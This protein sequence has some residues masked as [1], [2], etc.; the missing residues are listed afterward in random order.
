MA[1]A[2]STPPATTTDR[3]AATAP[4]LV[5]LDPTLLVRDECNAREHDTEPDAKLIT[6]VKELG[7]E[8]PISVRPLPDGTYGVF[9]GWR[10]A[11]AAQA[12]NASAEQDGRPVRTVNAYV[13]EDLVGNDAWTRFL[14]LVENDHRENMSERDTLKAQELSLIGMDDLQRRTA[15]KALGVG[16]NAARH[17]KAAQKLN[18]ASLRRS[19]A[20]GMDLEQTA[21]LAEVADAPRAEARLMGALQRD[22]EEGK[23]GRGHW[24][25]ELAL[26][27]ADLADAE[28]RAKAVADLKEAGA[29]LLGRVSS[30][31]KD[32]SKPLT[33]LTTALGNPLTEDNHKNCP[34]HSA[35]LDEEHRP[36]WHCADPAEYGHKVRPQPKKPKTEQ[37]ERKVEE[38][39]RTVAC[40]RAWK[41]AAGPRQEFIK[42]LVRGKTL[43]DE[44]RVF[45]QE[46]L[47]DLPGFYSSWVS[48]GRTETLALL[49]GAKE[50]EKDSPS[51]T[52]AH[53]P[54]A[55]LANLVFAQVAAA[56]EDTMREP[57]QWD[58]ARMRTVCVWEAPDRRQ[59]AYL[60]LLEALGKAADGS[61]QLS[62]VEQQAVSGRRTGTAAEA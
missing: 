17:A 58:S 15:A 33:Q 43:P 32:P 59:T 35:R 8:E 6:S 56:F 30:Y 23:G 3:R 16:R 49:L 21:Q 62:E 47:L 12:A 13:R 24:D 55:R 9:K 46:I 57:K 2:V 28:A 14:S 10:R 20:A 37:D 11:Q 34:G 5:Q 51:Q 60:L 26:L 54:K 22:Q 36:V 53:F 61:Y 38:R 19:A 42:R 41:A 31:A 4:Q 39:R 7:V 50:P 18:D 27:R 25:Q 44:A 48:K 1:T 52:A 40:N 45:A 29:T